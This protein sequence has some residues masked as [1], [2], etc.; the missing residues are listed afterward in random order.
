MRRIAKTHPP[1]E[2][3][4]W[5]DANREANHTYRDLLGTAAHV[6]LKSKLLEEQGWLCA[7]TGRS[8]DDNSAHVEHI[9]PQCECAEWEDVEYRNVVACFPAD[10]GDVS[11]GYGAPVKASWWEER[12]F[13][14]PLSDECERRFRFVW[15]GHVYPNPD[16]HEGATAT[17]V[18]LQLDAES[19][20]QLRKAR[21]D[22]FFGFG[23]RSRAKP[24][25]IADARTALVNLE[26]RDSNGHFQ[27]F[28]FVLKQLLPKYINQARAAV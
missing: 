25:T 24:L 23:P 3:T 6:A 15:S 18:A 28:C 13:V 26:R 16:D 9:K 5:R 21:V 17:I 1:R 19:L 27:E 22:G 12:Q 11:H 14:S 10:G 7:Y 4:T 8:I 20:R 2:V